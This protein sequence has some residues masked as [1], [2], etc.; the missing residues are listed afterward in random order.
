MGLIL[1][2]WSTVLK[3]KEMSKLRTLFVVIVG[4]LLSI[5][6]ISSCT[7]GSAVSQVGRLTEKEV[8]AFADPIAE[9]LLQAMNTSDYAQYTRDFDEAFKKN[10]SQNAFKT[11]NSLRIETVG[12]Y[13]SKEYWQMAQK[14]DKITVAYRAKFTDDPSVIF[15]AYFKNIEGKWYVDGTYYDSPLMRKSGC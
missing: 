12:S 11:I 3:T 7:P 13:V 9:N 14:N 10:L 8:R 4:L 1:M 15:T 6:F 2:R 5:G